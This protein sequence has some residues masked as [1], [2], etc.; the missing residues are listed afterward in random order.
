M[1]HNLNENIKKYRKEMNLTQADLAEAFGITEGAVSKWESGNTVPDISILMDLADFFDISVDTLLGYSI[2][3]KSI[4][5]I[6]DKLKKL[7]DE[8]EYDEA[9]KASESAKNWS[10]ISVVIYVVL[11][12]LYLIFVFAFGGMAFWA[13]M[14]DA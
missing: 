7:L 8:G 11:W 14:A 4:D 1:Q 5:S 3:S 9:I 2:S 10:I 13:S 12:I 6:T